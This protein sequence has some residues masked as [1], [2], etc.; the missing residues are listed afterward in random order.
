VWTQI[1]DAGPFA[2][3][4]RYN[5]AQGDA[6]PDGLRAAPQWRTTAAAAEVIN[7]AAAEA[8]LAA[9]DAALRRQAEELRAEACEML[10]LAVAEQSSSLA[11][12]KAENQVLQGQL[13]AQQ[14]QQ[15]QQQ[16]QQQQQQQHPQS[17]VD[18]AAELRRELC[19]AHGF[20]RA[21]V[22]DKA[23]A[24]TPA[25]ELLT[26]P[27]SALQGVG[28]KTAVTLES[29]GITTIG[30][31]AAWKTLHAAKQASDAE[32]GSMPAVGLASVC[33]VEAKALEALR[34][35]TAEELASWKFASFAEAI[36]RIE[37]S[38]DMSLRQ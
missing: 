11:A 27:A 19:T 38:A 37:Q 5:D 1:E 2:G 16:Q 12:A 25:A 3:A 15:L 4:R 31:L 13:A 6:L 26:L 23:Y 8:L 32:E 29:V 28:G 36:C 24:D 10:R 22:L 17:A 34:L 35:K 14:Q 21:A 9:H 18:E 30:E 7:S 20:L 33:A